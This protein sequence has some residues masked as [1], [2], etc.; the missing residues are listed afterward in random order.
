[1]TIPRHGSIKGATDFLA[2]QHAWIERTWGRMELRLNSMKRPE[3]DNEIW[4]RGVKV[5][6][7]AEPDGD[8]VRVLAGM[9]SFGLAR[10]GEDVRDLVGRRLREIAVLELPPRVLELGTLHGSPVRR[11]TVRDQRS[12][13]GSCSLRGTIS[14][15]W[16]LAHVPETIRDY[17]IVHELMHFRE[18]NH[19]PRFWAHV[20]SACPDFENNRR[21]LRE[22]ARIL[23]M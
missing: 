19:S 1:M 3:L 8:R 15:N 21:W 7:Q 11:V 13:W 18:M 9:E 12:R 6:I 23:G 10:E 16:R 22:H 17:V 2:K 20:R 14:L 5:L 4:C